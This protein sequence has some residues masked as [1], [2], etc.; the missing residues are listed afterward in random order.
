[1]NMKPT[2]TILTALL[3]AAAA[4]ADL[5]ALLRFDGDLKDAA[6]RHDGARSTR[7]SRLTSRWDASEAPW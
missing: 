2:L 6:G 5:V 4:H 7:S 1:M 3:L